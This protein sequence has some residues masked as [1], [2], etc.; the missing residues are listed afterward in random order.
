[1]K[2][3]IIGRQI[4]VYEDTKKMIAEKLE[5]LDRYF[6]QEGEATATLSR[7]HNVSTLELTIKASGMLMRSEVDAETFR[8]ALDKSIDNIERQIR[9][10]KAKLKKRLREGIDIKTDMLPDLTDVPEETDAIIR[11][12]Y[13]K[14]T[15]MTAEEAIMQMNLLEHTFFVYT[16][17]E[18]GKTCV[19]YQRK[20]GNY[21]VIIPE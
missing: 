3:N 17:A 4:T 1:M 2:V 18:E 13:F 16:D 15:P 10:N 12:K 8:D 7:K 21:G 5:K 14:M 9:R 20:D 11:R 6:P 19:V